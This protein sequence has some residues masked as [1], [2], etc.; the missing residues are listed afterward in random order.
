MY[1]IRKWVSLILLFCPWHLFAL[2]N[3]RAEKVYIVADSSIYN[4]KT[5]VNLFEGHVQVK[6]GTTHLTA[7]RLIT[8]SN[9]Q[10]KVQEAIAYG[11]NQ[12][13]DYW[14]QPKTNE[15]VLH[16]KAHII[17][18][19]PVQAQLTLQGDVVITQGEN[20]FQGQLILYNMKDKIITVPAS[21]S[22]HSVLIFNPDK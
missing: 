16:A 20:S 1:R 7:D 9:E 12:P 15:P 19:Y 6:Q 5:G 2:Q 13:A 11:L 17:K 18:F 8:K 4:Y 22:G 10:H 21:N 3:D 14:T